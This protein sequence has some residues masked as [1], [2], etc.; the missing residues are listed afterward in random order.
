[1]IS[2]KK[3][4][5][6]TYILFISLSLVI[7]TVAINIFSSKLFESFV[8]D[9]ISQRNA[10]IVRAF[11]EAYVPANNAFDLATLEAI[12][13]LFVHEGYIARLEGVAGNIIWDAHDMDMQHCLDVM[14]NITKRMEMGHGVKGELQNIDYPI[15]SADKLV[16]SLNITTF[17]PY[18][19]TE[20]EEQFLKSLNRVLAIATAVLVVLSAT[21]SILLA[22]SIAN[23]INTASVAAQAIA[24]FYTGGTKRETLNIRIREDYKTNELFELSHS[25][26]ELATQLAEMERRQKQLTADVAH[27]LRTP[28]A[29]LQGSIEAMSDGVLEP[30]KE[31]L[32]S[33]YDEIKR[34]SKLVEDLSLLTGLEWD[35]ITL[36][37]SEFDM[38]ELLNNVSAQFA[39]AVKKKGLALN[40]KTRSIL[41]YG[42]YDR[43]KQVIINL[44]SNAVKYTDSGHISIENSAEFI[45][46]ISDSGICI[47]EESLPHIFERFYRVDK[48][49]GR[50][51]GG[52]GIGLAIA[53]AIVVAHGWKLTAESEL[54]RGTTFTIV[55][56]VNE[57]RG[58]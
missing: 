52:S 21:I 49:R 57:S 3:R 5:T 11:S 44:V 47:D 13:M 2:L 6:I 33:C 23:P 30:T 31:L 58:A 20:T 17:G 22:N 27:E 18:F 1:M 56:G 14:G 43:I 36:N 25:I 50:E 9:S 54:G 45:F 29:C 38:Q 15:V 8:K 12:G 55:E 48:S 10:E 28:L 40:I 35:K 51:T 46:R 19:Y 4:L 24:A 53:S 37:K 7:L 16:G 39:V 32:A 41:I 34:L 42:D 26:N